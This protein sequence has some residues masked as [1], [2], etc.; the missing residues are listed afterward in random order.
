VPEALAT[1]EKALEVSPEKPAG[2]PEAL[3]IREE[4]RLRLRQ[5]D[6]A[7]ADFREALALAP[8]I[9][10]RCGN[11]ARRVEWLIKSVGEYKDE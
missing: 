8:R 9:G 7:Q 2:R 1:I 11:Y 3:R 4:W 10:R 5:T 6:A